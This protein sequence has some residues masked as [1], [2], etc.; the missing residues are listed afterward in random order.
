MFYNI[1]LAASS[2]RWDGPIR[3]TWGGDTLA[4]GGREPSLSTTTWSCYPKGMQIHPSRNTTAPPRQSQA[5][6][7][8][9]ERN[10]G[11]CQLGHQRRTRRLVQLADALL[12]H[13]EGPL[14]H[15]LQQPSAYRALCRLANQPT[16]THQA[17]LQGPCQTTLDSLRCRQGVS[18]LLHD[19]TE[20]D[21]SG[22]TTLAALG[23]IGNGHGQGY[24]CHNSLAVDPAT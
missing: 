23:Q 10:F 19:T 20:L 16:V 6:A 8:F 7:T 4:S 5:P 24:E 18:L 22:R 9:G 15:K 14:T 11:S 17:V 1:C 12:E 2:K 21:Y 13:P 3:S